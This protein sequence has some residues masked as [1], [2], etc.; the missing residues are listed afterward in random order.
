VEQD[1]VSWCYCINIALALSKIK[2]AKRKLRKLRE[3]VL[4]SC[5]VL[6]P[7]GQRLGQES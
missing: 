4:V 7:E 1:E 6:V 5:V 2:A 3:P